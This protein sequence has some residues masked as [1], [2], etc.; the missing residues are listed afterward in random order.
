LTD[1]EGS[2][3]VTFTVASDA[4]GPVAGKTLVTAGVE[5]ALSDTSRF[6]LRFHAATSYLKYPNQVISANLECCPMPAVRVALVSS[7]H[8][9]PNSTAGV[10]DGLLAVQASLLG[11]EFAPNATTSQTA[12][13]VDG[14]ATFDSLIILSGAAPILE[15][16]AVARIAEASTTPVIGRCIRSG[17]IAVLATPVT[18]SG[19]Q[20]LDDPS[21]NIKPANAAVEIGRGSTITA[22]LVITDSTGWP[23]VRSLNGASI[24]QVAVTASSNFVVVGTNPQKINTTTGIV[25]FTDLV[26]TETISAGVYPIVTF[27]IERSALSATAKSYAQPVTSGLIAVKNPAVASG[28]VEVV[29]EILKD[30]ATF[31][32]DQW[33]DAVATL[34]NVERARV[35]PL[36]TYVGRSGADDFSFDPVEANYMVPVWEGVRLE[37]IF[38]PPLPSSVDTRTAQ[39][40]ADF[41]VSLQPSCRLGQLAIRR[42]ALKAS[43]P[44][45]DWYIY[46]SQINGVQACLQARGKE[47]FCSCHLPLLKTLAPKCIGLQ[48]LANLC[49]DVLISSAAAN[50]QEPEI[51]QV[52]AKFQFPDTPREALMASGLVLGAFLPFLMYGYSK[53]YFHTLDRPHKSTL[54]A[55]VETT[56]DDFL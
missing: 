13:L 37:M 54:R 20:F 41:F 16:C 21:M 48:R 45:C 6:G 43:D 30:F 7:S 40:L 38:L 29:V 19:L 25:T 1:V 12:L 14:I 15:F 35:T 11:G 3:R 44:T 2:Y 9:F 46:D 51:L 33:L 31:Q 24:G 28:G 4:G 23:A 55:R 52:C 34:M 18:V 27:T 10:T 8:G 22:R 17:A 5:V 42:S 36:Y 39:E 49:L 47:G 50:C 53:R 32:R 26:F 56:P